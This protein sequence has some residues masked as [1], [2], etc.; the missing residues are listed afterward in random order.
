[1][2]LRI[3]LYQMLVN[4]IPVIQKKYYK[5][6]LE[7]TGTRGRLYAWASLLWMNLLW[8]AGFRDMQ[9]EILYPDSRKSIPGRPESQLSL[10]KTPEELAEAL[11][12][13]DIISFDIFDTLILRPVAAPADLFFFVGEKLH[14]M[15]FERIRRMAE[16]EAR[17]KAYEDTGSYEVTLAQIFREME[18][19][20]GIPGEEGMRAEI[21][22]ELAFCYANPY[23]KEVFSLLQEKI[24]NTGK[25]IICTSDMYLSPETLHAMIEKCG[26]AGIGE[27]FVSC[28]EQESK[29][30]GKLY[31]KITRR[32]GGELHYIHI[33]DNPESDGKKAKEAGWESVLYRNVNIAGMPYRAEDMSAVTGSLYR[34]IVNGRIHNGLVGYPADYEMGYIYGGIFAVGYCQFVHN[35][36]AVH[37]IDKI[38]FLSRDGEILDKVYRRL[39]QKEGEAGLDM[40]CCEA[41]YV[42]WS[43]TVAV[44]LLAKY[45]RYDFLRRFVDHKINSGYCLSDIFRSMGLM[46]M[47]ADFCGEANGQNDK[48]IAEKRSG[49]A[50]ESCLTDKN[51]AIVKEYLISHWSEVLTHYED[52]MEAAGRY[53]RRVLKNCNHAVVVDV[54]WAGSGALSLDLLVKREWKPDCEITGIIAGTNTFHNAEPD[55]TEPFLYTGKL[56][57]YLYSQEQ[58]REYWKWHNPGKNHNLLVEQLLSSKEGSLADIVTDKESREGYR[59]VF[60]E[61]DTE[62]GRVMQIQRGILDF[63]EDYQRYIPEYYRKSHCISGADAYAV[64]KILLQSKVSTELEMGI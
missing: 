63:A 30:G 11:S 50:P 35:Y 24:K 37:N 3:Y 22:T 57:S 48:T 10:Q 12:A 38:L 17:R 49:L 60:K 51:A 41:E 16:Q 7:K 29:A 62:P 21:E 2:K 55:A 42:Y 15:D 40:S 1:M 34:G 36:A 13:A 23:M 27:I 64:L 8:L 44:K 26:Y 39:Y 4:R 46:D 14:F 53:Y 6:R 59:F 61:P 9:E 25:K 19:K 56:V 33:G 20:T 47:L 5:L 31:R 32:Y 58:N 43:R 28:F 54:G 18:N 52:S 45:D